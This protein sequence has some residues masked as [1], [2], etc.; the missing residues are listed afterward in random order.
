MTM[1]SKENFLKNKEEEEE[2]E[3]DEGLNIAN[4]S[5]P[6]RLEYWRRSS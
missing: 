1:V 6:E 3:Q 4:A 5:D 2:K